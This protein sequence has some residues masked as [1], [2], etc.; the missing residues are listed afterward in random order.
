MI[1][2]GLVRA[3]SAGAR[4]TEDQTWNSFWVQ[5]E[6]SISVIAVCPTAYRSLFLINNST[7]DETPDRNDRPPGQGSVLERF[8]RRTKPSLQSIKVSATM[9]GVRTMIRGAGKTQL[10]SQDDDGYALSS[11]VTQYPHSSL[12]LETSKRGAG[13]AHEQV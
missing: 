1:A 9:T 13:A 11:V 4:G 10:G 3:I 2:I 6:A 5:M 12:S 7:P 8:W